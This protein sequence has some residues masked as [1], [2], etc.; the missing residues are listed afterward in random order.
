M[1]GSNT[2]GGISRGHKINMKTPNEDLG[3]NCACSRGAV[4]IHEPLRLTRWR[5][6]AGPEAG[7]NQAV[8]IAQVGRQNGESYRIRRAAVDHVVTIE[9]IHAD[10]IERRV[11]GKLVHGQ[12]VGVGPHTELRII[13][14]KGRVS[15]VHLYRVQPPAA[16]NWIAGF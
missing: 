14:E 15:R 4:H 5:R 11:V 13:T 12:V 1:R 3:L 8:L 6:I 10:A 9:R 7:R 16:G 2:K